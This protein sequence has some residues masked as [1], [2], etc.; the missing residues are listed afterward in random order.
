MVP[1]YHN[2]HPGTRW[3]TTVAR[4]QS[5]E[6]SF[7]MAWWAGCQPDDPTGNHQSNRIPL[8]I[9]ELLCVCMSQI[10]H[11]Q[12]KAICS[13]SSQQLPMVATSSGWSTIFLDRNKIPDETPQDGVCICSRKSMDVSICWRLT[14][15]M[16]RCA[17][18]AAMHV[19]RLT[20]RRQFWLPP[21]VFQHWRQCRRPA[22]RSFQ[23]PSTA[24]S[25]PQSPL[26]RS[27]WARL[28]ESVH[29]R[30]PLV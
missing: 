2:V 26:I 6:G 27:K 14:A 5:I 4:D 12:V 15:S 19:I 17:Q 3:A 1:S 7:I 21:L 10:W 9:H 8:L 30:R 22:W 16:L 20:V 28:P 24:V 29:V 18:H 25:L 11:A 23:A 13:T